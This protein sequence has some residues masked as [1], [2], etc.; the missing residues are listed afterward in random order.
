MIHHNAFSTIRCW[1]LLFVAAVFPIISG[2]AITA[3]QADS[4]VESIGINTHWAYKG[5]YTNN[6]TALRVKLVESGIRYVR[7]RTVAGVFTR[8]NDLY[9]NFGIKTNMLTARWVPGIWPAPLDPTQIDAELNDIK[10]Q[11]LRS[12]DAIEAPNEYDHAHGPD[13][14]WLSTIKNYS[15]NL[16]NKVKADPILKNFPVIGPSLVNYESYVAVGNSDSFIDYGNQHIY[17]WTYWPGFSGYDSNGTRSLDWYLNLLARA[18]SPSGKPLIAT[19]TG[20]TTFIEV[21]GLSEEADGKYTAR[22]LA[23]F[24]RRGIYRTYKYELV[25]E[26]ITGREGFFGLL[27]NNLTEKASF[28]AVRNLISILSDKGSAF[29][30]ASLNYTL[31]G[32]LT[33]VRQLLFQKRN[34]DFYLMVWNEVSSWDIRLKFDLYPSPQQLQ[35]NVQGD[36]ILTDVT[37]YSFNNNA[38]VNVT[39][40]PVINNQVK[41]NSTDKISILQVKIAT[42]S[43]NSAIG[44]VY[45]ITPKFAPQAALYAISDQNHAVISQTYYSGAANQQW[46]LES[47]VDG[48][49]RIKNRVGGRVLDI[50]NCNTYDGGVTRLYDWSNTDCQKWKVEVLSNGY[51][52]LTPKHAPNQSLNVQL[53]RSG[54]GIIVQQS[55]WSNSDCQLWKLE[56]IE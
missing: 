10:T 50:D 5:V 16:Y 22:L 6:Y 43:T 44:G 39:S 29:T 51:Y 19:E 55:S 15:I 28:R 1:C 30:P 8:A 45:R 13:T 36:R 47:L 56:H 40:L 26:E 24:F 20:H 12:V 35:L 54:G 49:Y 11:A 52:R 34:G 3:V 41:F 9:D 31:T 42:V 37:L 38:D 14:N 48:F 7:D 46:I 53:C 23:E 21:G 18:Q 32:N 25:D 33:N 4:F 17:Y 2:E 27:R